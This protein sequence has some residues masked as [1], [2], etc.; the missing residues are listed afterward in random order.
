LQVSLS[1]DNEKDIDLYV[2]QPDGEIIF[3]GNPGNYYEKD[4]EI[5]G[6]GLDID[7][8][9]ACDIDGINNENVFY[10]NEYIQS[11]KYE[12]WIN[13]YANCN[14]YIS[15]NW[16]VT[17]LYEGALVTTTYGRNPEY[18]VFSVN[19]PS[20]PISNSLD[21]ATKVMEFTLSGRVGQSRVS[22]NNK[23]PNPLTESAKIKL[24]NIKK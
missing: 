7:S 2:V 22:I 5:Q 16:I 20:N 21:G 11:G 15:T 18:G 13:M 10:S 8:N 14:E 17:A 9:A 4:G 23:T 1:F 12:V 3:Y 19:T 6:W 24:F